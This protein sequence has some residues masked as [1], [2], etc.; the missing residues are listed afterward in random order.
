MLVT[1][2]VTKLKTLTLCLTTTKKSFPTMGSQA[3]L[4][5]ASTDGS[6]S[7]PG[8]KERVNGGSNN[9]RSVKQYSENKYRSK[10]E[11][12]MFKYIM[13]TWTI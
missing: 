11:T 3:L 4:M 6:S 13:Y 2:P 12:Y 7:P 10:A 1:P 9:I 5:A 8:R